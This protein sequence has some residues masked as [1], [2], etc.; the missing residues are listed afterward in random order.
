M[1]KT[2][3]VGARSVYTAVSVVLFALGFMANTQSATIVSP[4][5]YSGF[6]Q[7][8]AVVFL[9]MSSAYLFKHI[10]LHTKGK[11]ASLFKAVSL[12]FLS[13]LLIAWTDVFTVFTSASF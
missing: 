2:I 6:T 7:G 4:T 1:F 10:H 9:L 3:D 8:I 12:P 13:L 11:K 5:I